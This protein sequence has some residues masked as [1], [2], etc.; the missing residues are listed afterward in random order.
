MSRI[1]PTVRR[2]RSAARV[3]AS[4]SVRLSGPAL[5][6]GR[7]VWLF[8]A[9]FVLGLDV[10]GT[11]AA[12]QQSLSTCVGDACGVHQLTPDQMRGLIASGMSVGAYAVY[13]VSLYW[14]G[15]LVYAA[16]ALVIFW[17][18]SD[19]RMALFG[20]YALLLFGAGPVFGAVNALPGG[21]TLWSPAIGIVQFFGVLAFYVFFCVFPSGH[22]APRWMRWIA[23]SWVV[24]HFVSLI[25]YIPLQSFL[26]GPAPFAV[27]FGLLVVAQVYRY[28]SVSTPV[29]REQTKWVVYGIAFGLG[30]FLVALGS[31][32]IVFG[33]K[34]LNTALGI[35]GTDTA[36][37]L[38]LCLIPLFI[39]IAITRSR[40]WDID[41]LINR[42]LV[43]GML[44]VALA[45]LYFAS[46]AIAQYA[47]EAI[48]GQTRQQPVIIVA[49]TLLAV[50]LF[51]PLQ[52]SIQSVIDRRF[53]R[54][55]YDAQKTLAS[56]SATLRQQ[57]DLYELRGHLLT[58]VT[59]TM[60]PAHV[61]LWLHQP[62]AHRDGLPRQA[63][64][65]EAR[66]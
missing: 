45:A 41:I 46:V 58:V 23:L 39:G 37:A 62:E 5:V 57:V 51:R 25:P 4:G 66:R 65:K 52:R 40:L 60:Q 6:L 3:G 9:V 27:I 34:Q 16:I 50:A 59:E 10:L 56:F 35:V 19:E 21:G 55:K 11:P 22:F 13:V 53:Y 26:N 36:M 28:R 63:E 47:V 15:T 64:L 24:G 42:T 20:A 31:S 49:S 48:S 7:A 30:G 43:Y 61:S 12:Y 33:P 18:R 1:Y 38:L 54:R 8:L 32:N 2:P 29:Q 14:F 17:R 44:T